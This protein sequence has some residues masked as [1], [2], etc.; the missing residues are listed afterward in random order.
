[1]IFWIRLR[2]KGMGKNEV[3]KNALQRA[4]VGTEK[5]TKVYGHE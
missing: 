3:E 5:L 1:M 2:L 4:K